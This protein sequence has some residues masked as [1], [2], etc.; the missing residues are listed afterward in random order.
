MALA[1]SHPLDDF[2]DSEDLVGSVH[3]GD[4]MLSSPNYPPLS[5]SQTPSHSCNHL[6]PDEDTLGSLAPTTS[7]SSSDMELIS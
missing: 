2:L 6:L 3:N 1:L 4:P 5:P 7:C